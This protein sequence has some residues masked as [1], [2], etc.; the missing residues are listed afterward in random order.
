MVHSVAVPERSA[1]TIVPPAGSTDTV[2]IG[3]RARMVVKASGLPA[4]AS[5]TFAVPSASMAISMFP[6]GL[7]VSER[8]EPL[9]PVSRAHGSS[10][11]RPTGGIPF[12][13]DGG[14]SPGSCVGGGLVSTTGG[15]ARASRTVSSTHTSYTPTDLSVSSTASVVPS[16]LN[17]TDLS[18]PK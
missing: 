12:G 1:V 16:G 11:S 5:H 2:V 7:N 14:S 17:A 4:F 3:A 9:R 6:S 13:G 8:A 15:S 10:G 18:E